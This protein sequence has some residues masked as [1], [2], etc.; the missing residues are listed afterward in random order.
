MCDTWQQIINLLPGSCHANIASVSDFDTVPSYDNVTLRGTLFL[1]KETA[2]VDD[3]DTYI[4]SSYSLAANAQV[5]I[6]GV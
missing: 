3:H 2:M 4:I 6:S 1:N 5:N